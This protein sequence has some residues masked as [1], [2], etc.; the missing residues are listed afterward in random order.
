MLTFLPL[1]FCRLIP[2]FV[3]FLSFMADQ[4]ELVKSHHSASKTSTYQQHPKLL[5]RSLIFRHSIDGFYL[6]AMVLKE[7]LNHSSV[8][9]T[10]D[11]P[12]KWGRAIT[13]A[14]PHYFADTAMPLKWVNDDAGRFQLFGSWPCLRVCH[15]WR[16]AVNS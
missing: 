6:F 1:G 7:G 15:W 16:W 11:W 10:M 13:S 9:G 8:V 3:P 14:R 5:L 12:K 2:P 4:H